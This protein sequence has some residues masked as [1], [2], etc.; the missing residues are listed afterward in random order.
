MYFYFNKNR[1]KLLKKSLTNEKDIS[2]SQNVEQT[3]ESINVTTRNDIGPA[4]KDVI[5]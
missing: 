4:Q 5:R 2:N 1:S 3:T